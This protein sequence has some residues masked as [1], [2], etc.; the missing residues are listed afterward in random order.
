MTLLIAVST[1]GVLV[2]IGAVMVMPLAPMQGAMW[3]EHC[4]CLRGLQQFWTISFFEPIVIVLLYLVFGQ[5]LGWYN[6]AMKIVEIDDRVAW[7]SWVAS[8]PWAHPLQ[9]W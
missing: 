1:A 9:L 7:D 3:V 5:V 4:N 2:G 8:H 6:A